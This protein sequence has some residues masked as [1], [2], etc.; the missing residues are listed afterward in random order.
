MA[1]SLPEWLKE[2]IMQKAYSLQGFELEQQQ[3]LEEERRTLL[4]QLGMLTLDRESIIERLKSVEVRS[5]ALVNAIAHRHQIRDYRQLMIQGNQLI[6]DVFEPPQ[7]LN[8]P[9]TPAP[10]SEEHPAVNGKGD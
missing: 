8:L 1:E 4:A 7:P 5:R 2:Q 3:S 6:G 10:R 9:L